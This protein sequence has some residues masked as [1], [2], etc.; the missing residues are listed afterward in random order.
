MQKKRKAHAKAGRPEGTE[1]KLDL[2]E[3]EKL[4]Q[5]GCTQGE[6]ANFLG[7]SVATIETR[8]QREDFRKAWDKG[9]ATLNL[10]IRRSQVKLADAGNATML[11][12]LGKQRLGQKDRLEATGKDDGPLLTLAG[13]H[14]YMANT[15]CE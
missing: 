7:V 14:A 9:Q 1:A 8:L 13:I 10:S 2:V 6:A 5:L 3:F 12:W 11:I 15:D 4:A